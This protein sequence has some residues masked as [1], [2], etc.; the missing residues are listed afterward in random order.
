[1][2]SSKP[3]A[4]KFVSAVQE[5]TF[6][7]DMEG[8]G[9]AAYILYVPLAT[10]LTKDRTLGPLL[11]GLNTRPRRLTVSFRQCSES[12]FSRPDAL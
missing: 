3:V 5:R 6:T 9:V 4:T 12:D 10:F 8:Y 7:G 2:K 1:M 11:K